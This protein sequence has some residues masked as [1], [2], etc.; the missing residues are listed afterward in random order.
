M[1]RW[2]TTQQ[3][4]NEIAAL[5]KSNNSSNELNISQC[6]NIA[7]TVRNLYANGGKHSVINYTMSTLPSFPNDSNG[8]TMEQKQRV[9]VILKRLFRFHVFPFS[10]IACN[11][12]RIAQKKK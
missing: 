8:L 4:A 5:D 12:I 9:D 1:K 2:L 3:M 7:K 10:R 11:M 6:N